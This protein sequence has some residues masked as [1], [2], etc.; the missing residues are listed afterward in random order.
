MQSITRFVLIGGSAVIAAGCSETRSSSTVP[1]EPP[2]REISRDVPWPTHG[3]VFAAGNELRFVTEG[4]T[5]PQLFYSIDG[6]AIVFPGWSP[7]GTRMAFSMT[8][9]G[10]NDPWTIHVL[11]RAGTLQRLSTGGVYDIAPSWSPDG[12]RIAFV[13]RSVPDGNDEV[14]VMNADGRNRVRITNGGMRS[15]PGFPAWSPDG[16]RIAYT[17]T[18]GSSVNP[19]TGIY[20][21]KPDGTDA[22]RLTQ[23]TT[24]M[25]FG[26]RPA[27]SPDG[28][29]LAF[30]TDDQRSIG[31]LDVEG[32]L[33]LGRISL[34]T[35]AANLAW[36]PDGKSI[37]FNDQCAEDEAE[38]AGTFIWLIQ[39]ADGSLVRM[40]SLYGYS[41]AWIR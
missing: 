26:Q 21:V 9:A 37:A 7:D 15:R 23:A 31:F 8:A 12:S 11:D 22:E 41:P 33:D 29:R 38:C 28:R 20:V 16:T 34:P 5:L 10:S 36:S 35:L 14:Y 24:P 18:D 39:T 4:S 40:P 19:H 13:S 25:A 17:W 32:K 2:V 1:L 6:A 30:L 27:W 3:V